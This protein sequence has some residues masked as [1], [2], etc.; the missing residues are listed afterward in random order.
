MGRGTVR[1]APAARGQS[2]S[3]RSPCCGPRP[4]AFSDQRD[5]AAQD[6]RRPG[7]DRDR[8]R[9]PVQRDPARRWSSRPRPPR[10]CASSASS[11]T[12]VQPVFDA[13]ARSGVRLFKGAA[14]AVS[15]P[16][17]RRACA[18]WRS[19]KTIRAG[20][21]GWRDVVS[22]AAG[23]GYIH[24][25]AM[26]DCRVVDVADVLQ[27]RRQFEAPEAQPRRRRDTARCS[28]VP[29]VRD[30]VADRR[31][32]G[33][34][35]RSPGR[36][37]EEQIAL[38]QT[39]ADQAV[40]AIENVRLFNETKEALRAADGDGRGPE[41]DQQL[42]RPTPQPVFDAIARELRSGCSPATSRASAGRRGRLIHLRALTT[43]APERADLQKRLPDR[44]PT[45]GGAM[46][47]GDAG[48]RALHGHLDDPTCRPVA[49]D[50]RNASASARSR[51]VIAPMLRE[52]EAIGSDHVIRA[53]SRSASATRQI[54]LLQT[55]AD[56]AVIAIENVR[57][58]NE[59]QGSARAADRHRR[60]PAGDQQLGDRCCSRSSTRSL[61]ELRAPVRRRPARGLPGRRRGRLAARWRI[62][63]PTPS[64]STRMRRSC[65]C[66]SPVTAT[67]AAI[68]ERRSITYP[69]V[70]TIAEFPQGLRAT[71]RAA[72]RSAPSRSL[73]RR[74]CGRARRSASIVRRPHRSR[75]RSPTSR[76]R[77][78]RPSP[79]RR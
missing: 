32:R 19:P 33:R 45:A 59:T 37:S 38:L 31:D 52:G 11:P 68:R 20:A 4:A 63:G 2:R 55:F 49:G 26:L 72:R 1:G 44:P 60:D 12:D 9:A 34:S 21:R 51:M 22:V 58:F 54:E 66:R 23:R 67:R 17:R 77:C 69:D 24:G 36:F 65:P 39:F 18:R 71:A 16:R 73:S 62:H 13:I 42:G 46:S 15:R 3:A 74:C 28:V 29:M 57:L 25:A 56:Q 79:T 43:A 47:S 70:L 75:A 5:R 7:R 78:C 50:R 40:I 6:L 35:R 41:G 64:G 53:A 48:D 27:A 10:S 14:V 8:E 76:S 30:G 61:A